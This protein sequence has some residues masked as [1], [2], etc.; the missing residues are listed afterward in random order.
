[1]NRN[2]AKELPVSQ[3][4]EDLAVQFFPQIN[5]AFGPIAEAKPHHV[6]SCMSRI[7][8]SYHRTTP[9]AESS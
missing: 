8:H 9:G 1:M 6:V 5:F 2:Q 4:R 7:D 3:R